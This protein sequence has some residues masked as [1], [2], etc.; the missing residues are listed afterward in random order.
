[1]QLPSIRRFNSDFFDVHRI[2]LY[3]GGKKL[4]KNLLSPKKPLKK[5]S[6]SLPKLVNMAIIKN[7]FIKKL[8]KIKNESIANIEP[9]DGLKT[10]FLKVFK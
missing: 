7:K 5:E 2:N 6:F 1:M 10:I 3:K 9:N 4:N 8:L